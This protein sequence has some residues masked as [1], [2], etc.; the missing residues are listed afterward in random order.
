MDKIR[1]AKVSKFDLFKGYWQVPLTE[2]AKEMSAFVTPDVLFQYKVMSFCMKNG[3]ATFQKMVHSLL[4]DIQGCEAYIDR[5]QRAWE[6]H[7]QIM[8]KFF[9]TLAKAKLTTN[10]AKS[11]VCHATVEYLCHKVGHGY[12]VPIMANM[13]TFAKFPIPMS[14]KALMRFLSFLVSG[15]YRKFCPNFSLTVN[16]IT[17]LL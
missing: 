13:E 4:Y 15:F 17:N 3:P 5:R 16:L 10:L 1:S 8:Y 6:E 9:D 14:K 7:L 12:V 2:K 11:D